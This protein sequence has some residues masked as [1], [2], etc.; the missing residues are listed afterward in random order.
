LPTPYSNGRLDRASFDRAR[1]VIPDPSDPSPTDMTNACVTDARFRGS[2]LSGVSFS[3]AY[4][5]RVDFTDAALPVEALKG[6]VFSQPN[7]RDANVRGHLPAAWTT[8]GV[9]GRSTSDIEEICTRG[10]RYPATLP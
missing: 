3:G 4:G 1:F 7:V 5:L 8:T 10:R 2:D 6:A 9:K